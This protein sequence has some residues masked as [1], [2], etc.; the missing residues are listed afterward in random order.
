MND[1]IGVN[2]V[3]IIRLESGMYIGYDS[4]KGVYTNVADPNMAERVMGDKELN[5]NRILTKYRA[6]THDM[7]DAELAIGTYIYR[8]DH[9]RSGFASA[10]DLAV[11]YL[12]A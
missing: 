12:M 4:V 2:Q 11:R 7:Q 3:G 1:I 6:L 10:A 9:T 8:K 5:V